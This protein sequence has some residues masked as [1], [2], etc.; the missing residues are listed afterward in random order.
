[1]TD[2]RCHTCGQEL[3]ETDDVQ[4][5]VGNGTA[6][7]WGRSVRLRPQECRLL[8]LLA[9]RRP[10]FV[11]HEVIFGFLYEDRPDPPEAG[12]THV[13]VCLL[14]QKIER[15]T[16]ATL[17]SQHSLGCRLVRKELT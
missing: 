14:R 5:D 9:A 2:H 1:M 8:K 13:A 11:P 17:E 4:V 6:V 12:S 15:E 16:D 10:N 3:K 7:L